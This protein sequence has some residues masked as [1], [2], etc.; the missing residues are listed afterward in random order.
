MGEYVQYDSSSLVISGENIAEAVQVDKKLIYNESYTLIGSKLSSPSIHACYNLTVLGDLEID[1]IEVKG[2]LTVLGNIKAK[3][4]NCLK[5][6]ICE[7]NIDAEVLFIGSDL[8]AD[9]LSCKQLS[10]SGH[11]FARTTIDIGQNIRVEGS[12]MAGEGIVGGG[13]FESK[14][15]VAGEYFE[16]VGAVNSKV[17][18]LETDTSFGDSSGRKGTD[19]LEY[20]LEELLPLIKSKLTEGLI[21]SGNIGENE[22]LQFVKNISDYYAE[23]VADWLPLTEYLVEFSY[24]DEIKNLRDYLILTMAKNVLPQEIL[25]YET[26]NHLYSDMFSEATKNVDDLEYKA[27]SVEDLIMSMKIVLNYHDELPIDKDVAFDKIFQ[28]IGIKYKTV[29]S[30]L[31]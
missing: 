18:E 4:I 2:K 11:V 20:T 7:G 26:L 10:C 28:S 25:S 14:N 15:A 17:L 31:K 6:L 16:F 5:T 19:A 3:R 13:I 9:N 30:F 22:L 27:T 24:L 1:E 21:Q 23:T 29:K 8:I 12:V